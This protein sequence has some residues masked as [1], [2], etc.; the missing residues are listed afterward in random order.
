MPMAIA[1][2]SACRSTESLEGTMLIESPKGEFRFL[3]G[4]GPYSSGAVS[5]RGLEIVDAIS[6]PALR[7]WL[8][9]DRVE[10]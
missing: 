10:D 3:K 6:N 2:G 5:A 9:F 8:A 4:S 1:A 7:L